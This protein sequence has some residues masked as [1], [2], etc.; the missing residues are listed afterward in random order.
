MK[1]L[2]L[3]TYTFK[4]ISEGKKTKIF[5]DIRRKYLTLTPEEWVRQHF[6]K[7]LIQE[8]GYPKGLIALEKG[9]HLNSLYK[10]TDILVYSKSGQPILMVECKSADVKI[11]QSVFDQISRYNLHYKLPYLIVSNGLEHYCAKLNF[12]TSNFNF[13][14]QLPAYEELH[15]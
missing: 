9:L 15:F 12:K 6:V 1:R 3:P 10:R 5:D 7:F 4:I 11:T 8:K 13:L 14:N 2:N